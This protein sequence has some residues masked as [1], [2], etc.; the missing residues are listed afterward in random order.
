LAR[1]PSTKQG[2]VPSGW[3]SLVAS[4]I[5][6]LLSAAVRAI[7]SDHGPVPC[8][9][10]GRPPRPA[11]DC[12]TARAGAMD[13]HSTIPVGA[14]SKA[15]SSRRCAHGSCQHTRLLT[16]LSS[17]PLSLAFRRL[18]DG[19]YNHLLLEHPQL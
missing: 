19:R 8:L 13:D 15:N 9:L 5:R 2:R 1:R 10:Q 7:R 6:A 4:A 14:T 17:P 18:N 12:S 16:R 3:L 11:P